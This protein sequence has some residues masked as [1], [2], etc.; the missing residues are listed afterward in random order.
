M[1]GITNQPRTRSP[2]DAR[3]ADAHRPAVPRDIQ[4]ALSAEQIARLERLLLP[5]P[6][7]HGFVYRV[8]TVFLGR[9][10]Y[11]AL[12]SGREGRS[13]Q[14]LALDGHKRA[15]LDVVFEMILLCLAIL[16]LACLLAITAGISLYL[17]KS[18]LGIDLTDGPSFLHRY[19][20]D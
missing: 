14:R 9:K 4:L 19:F 7:A 18:G 16:C 17:V 1:I 20:F 10:F 6:A 5:R 12:L 13:P 11:L 8:S 3:P 2:A 15:F